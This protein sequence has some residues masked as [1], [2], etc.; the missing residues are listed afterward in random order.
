MTALIFNMAVLILEVNT[1]MLE[2]A[3]ADARVCRC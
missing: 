2:S 1:L 3:G